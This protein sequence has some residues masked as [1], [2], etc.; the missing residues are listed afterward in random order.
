MNIRF[1]ICA[2]TAFVACSQASCGGIPD[3]SGNTATEED[4]LYGHYGLARHYHRVGAGG[5]TGVVGNPGAGTGGGSISTPVPAAPDTCDVCTKA[6]ACCLAVSDGTSCTYSA[7]TC[8][9]QPSY[10]DACLVELRTIQSV[11]TDPPAACR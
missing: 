8:E 7:E 11:W 10:I 5:G 3:E 6:N 9:S 2:F 4:A 1:S